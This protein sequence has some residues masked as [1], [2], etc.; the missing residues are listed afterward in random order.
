MLIISFLILI[1]GL[2]LLLFAGDYLVRGA[3]ALAEKIDKLTG[4]WAIDWLRS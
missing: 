1:A 2:I 4:F 3:V